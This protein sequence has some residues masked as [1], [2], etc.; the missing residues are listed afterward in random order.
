MKV[1]KI[2]DSDNETL[3]DEYDEEGLWKSGVYIVPLWYYW[4]E[5]LF[6]SVCSAF[7]VHLIFTLQV[8]GISTIIRFYWL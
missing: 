6:V 4:R 7:A 2:S 3:Y 8:P 1:P 5:V